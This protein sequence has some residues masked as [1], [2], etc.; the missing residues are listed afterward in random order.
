MKGRRSFA[1]KCQHESAGCGRQSTADQ[2]RPQQVTRPGQSPLDGADRP[3]E[4]FSGLFVRLSLQVAKDKRRTILRRQRLSSWS[5]IAASSRSA[6]EHSGADAGTSMSSVPNRRRRAASER[7]R[8]ATRI[9]TPCS[10]GP[11]ASRGPS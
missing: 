10:Q 6:N 8:R 1:A 3:P 4:L 2:S 7:A 9:A 11:I 5:R